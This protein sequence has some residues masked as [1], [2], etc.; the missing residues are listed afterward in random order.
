[1]QDTMWSVSIKTPVKHSKVTHK[2]MTFEFT[3]SFNCFQKP[4]S[5]T[6][7]TSFKI[8][9][10]RSARWVRKMLA[11]EKAAKQR[12]THS[13]MTMTRSHASQVQA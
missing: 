1:M 4:D 7:R 6:T 11:E 10:N 8:L 5:L 9:T 13:T 2:R 12:L 3:C